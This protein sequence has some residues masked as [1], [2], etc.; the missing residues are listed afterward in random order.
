[1]E[2]GIKTMTTGVLLMKAEARM[3][4]AD[5]TRS[6]ATGRRVAWLSNRLAAASRTPVRISVPESTNIAAMVIGAGLEKTAVI[7]SAFR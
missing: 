2:I 5:V 6:V 1:M 7:C 4:P 3:I